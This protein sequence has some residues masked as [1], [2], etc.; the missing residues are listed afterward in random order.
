MPATFGLVSLES[1]TRYYTVSIVS[2]W[3]NSKGFKRSVGLYKLHLNLSEKVYSLII[4]KMLLLGIGVKRLCHVT[5]ALAY[6]Y[7]TT[8]PAKVHIIAKTYPHEKHI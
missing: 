6:K 2:R 1:H 8:Y 5:S 3:R 4:T 7:V